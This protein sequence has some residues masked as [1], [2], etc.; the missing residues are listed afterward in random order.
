[1]AQGKE[2]QDRRLLDLAAPLQSWCKEGVYGRFMQGKCQ[3]TLDDDFVV[4][5]LSEVKNYKPLQQ[6]VLLVIMFLA[7][8]RMYFK[9]QHKAVQKTALVLDEAWSFLEA[10]AIREFVAGVARRARK[11]PRHAHYG[12]PECGR[13][14]PKRGLHGD[15]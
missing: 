6:Q 5:E 14:R 13:F 9:N 10:Q 8:N 15:L 1:M 11:Y 4:F 7:A 3:L 2:K 12:H